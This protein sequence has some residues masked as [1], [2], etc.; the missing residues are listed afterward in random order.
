MRKL[1][2]KIKSLTLASILRSVNPGLILPAILTYL[3]F[4][5]GK[6]DL[7]YDEAG[8]FWISQGLNHYSPAFS[9]RQGFL[10]VIENNQDYNFD[11]G[12]FSL[13]LFLWSYLSDSIY[14]LRLLPFLF[15][16]LSLVFV[17]LIAREIIDKYLRSVLLL[18]LIVLTPYFDISL[19][20]R[21]H[22][23]ELAMSTA[24]LYLLL[25]FQ[26]TLRK[27]YFY[28]FL[29][30]TTIL[31]LS[32]YDASII[33]IVL[34]ALVIKAI[35]ESGSKSYTAVFILISTM[36][37]TV[38][39]VYLFMTR[40]QNRNLKSLDYLTYL[41]SNPEFILR[42]R[43]IA[44]ICIH[45]FLVWLLLKS[46]KSQVKNANLTTIIKVAVYTNM[47]TLLLSL[48]NIAPW[49]P[50]S[51][52][53]PLLVLATLLALFG[54][55]ST[56]LGLISNL[57]RNVLILFLGIFIFFG[58]KSWGLVSM[59]R[60]FN[61]P[62]IRE[63]FNSENTIERIKNGSHVLVESSQSPSVR[64]LFE[65]TDL[66]ETYGSAYSANFTFLIGEVHSLEAQPKKS[67]H[68]LSDIEISDFKIIIGQNLVSRVSENF[69]WII[70]DKN[71][72]I[73]LENS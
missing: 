9:Q 49:D 50:Y 67:S 51:R 58:Y 11:P 4:K 19:F 8:Q 65:K 33:A 69:N 16:C 14:W 68:N 6:L 54:H 38:L 32:R 55:I 28:S 39:S 10:Q 70:L 47:L 7:W 24:A 40:Y 29:I 35:R 56:N 72:T 45:L 61:T 2:W 71:N 53:N 1:N 36:M 46:T 15:F 25:R 44:F 63:F 21:A 18:M 52:Q 13:L 12:G 31:L 30:V 57:S 37:C 5:Y 73:A 23:M 17:N 62:V 66:N 34:V 59:P 60:N 26:D 20:L 41:G 48:L 27:R 22:S 64:F 3:F 43:H 42:K